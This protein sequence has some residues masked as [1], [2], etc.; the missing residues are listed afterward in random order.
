MDH[1]SS[2]NEETLGLK[3][4][5]GSKTGPDWMCLDKQNWGDL[6][7]R[8]IQQTGIQQAASGHP[9]FWINQQE[10]RDP[11][12]IP[13]PL[14]LL[15]IFFRQYGSVA[16]FL[17]SRWETLQGCSLKPALQRPDIH[18]PL[19]CPFLFYSIQSF[20]QCLNTNFV[21]TRQTS[22]VTL[23]NQ[24]ATCQFSTI[25]H[26]GNVA[27]HNNLYLFFPINSQHLEPT[28]VRC[29]ISLYSLIS[30]SKT[31]AVFKHANKEVHVDKSPLCNW[32]RAVS[33]ISEMIK[34]RCQKYWY[35]KCTEF[36]P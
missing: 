20:F 15:H 23:A 26:N 19:F 29:R 4:S 8:A 28:H 16:F 14:C 5:S 34:D 12:L 10:W 1:T 17:C 36:C 31:S 9:S 2:S 6:P 11:V 33:P 22:D 7:L 13:L 30:S 3:A 18:H 32:Q 21:Q 24:C 27:P 25:F 35:S